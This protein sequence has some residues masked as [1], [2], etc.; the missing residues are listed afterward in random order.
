[1]KYV[2]ESTKAECPSYYVLSKEFVSSGRDIRVYK[3]GYSKVP[4]PYVIT[5]AHS[6]EHGGLSDLFCLDSNGVK[7]LIEALVKVL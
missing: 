6:K 4:Y 2:I 5:I 7:E 3:T 1:M